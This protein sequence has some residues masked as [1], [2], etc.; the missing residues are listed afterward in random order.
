MS[1]MAYYRRTFPESSVTAGGPL[2]LISGTLERD[3]VWA[4]G[5]TGSRV[6]SCGV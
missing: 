6:H 3:R 4:N 2:G 1:F 5:G